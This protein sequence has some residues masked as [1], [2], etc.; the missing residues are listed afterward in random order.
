MTS[1]LLSPA[2]E[3]SVREESDNDQNQS[4]DGDPEVSPTKSPTT[5]KSV[6][7]KNS[8]GTAQPRDVTDRFR[9]EVGGVGGQGEG[10]VSLVQ[11]RDKGPRVQDRCRASQPTGRR[12]GSGHSAQHGHPDSTADGVADTGRASGV[13]GLIHGVQ[14]QGP[15]GPS[16]R[17]R[18]PREPL[19]ASHLRTAP[20]APA[21]GPPAVQVA[22]GD[23][24]GPTATRPWAHSH[25]F[26][27]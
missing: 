12:R 1:F 24:T 13:D 6:K 17:P 26:S 5:P 27:E 15:G 7:S 19:L 18:S 11:M 21:H 4:D 20:P 16:Y 9:E 3:V 14:V 2:S 23:P 8:S 10:A 25:G 22:Q